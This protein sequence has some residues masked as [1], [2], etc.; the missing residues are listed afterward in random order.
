M[1][2]TRQSGLILQERDRHIFREL[3]VMRVVD[4]EQA[5]V[6]GGFG[7]SSR[8]NRRL[9]ALTQAGFLRRFF[10]GTA[11]AGRKAIYALAEKGALA[12][13]VPYKSLRRRRDEIIATDYFVQHQLT[14][15]A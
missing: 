13:E 14:V 7:S 6:V 10:L 12:V 1:N 3:A 11:P 15:N 2:S 5:K 9:R 4:G 8:T